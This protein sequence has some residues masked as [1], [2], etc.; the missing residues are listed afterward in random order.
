MAT[1]R[2]ESLAAVIRRITLT[3]TTYLA[4]TAIYFCVHNFL[5]LPW[6]FKA[7]PAARTLYDSLGGFRFELTSDI[8][9]RILTAGVAAIRE[10]LALWDIAG[11]GWGPALALAALAAAVILP[12]RG[13][14]RGVA[15]LIGL[16]GFAAAS[17]VPVVVSAGGAG[18]LRTVAPFSAIILG[19]GLAGLVRMPP[20]LPGMA[21][22]G[23]AAVASSIAIAPILYA[24]ATNS[25]LEIG[26]IRSALLEAMQADPLPRHIHVIECDPTPS[27][28][29]RPMLGKLEFN[30]NS[31]GG[32]MNVPWM[33]RSQ[34]KSMMSKKELPRIN[35]RKDPNEAAADE[36]AVTTSPA[37]SPRPTM[38]NGTLV[39]DMPAGRRASAAQWQ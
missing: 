1:M 9:G 4:S 10:G 18:G 30:V 24:S 17:L 29:G 12:L 22:G 26:Y 11:Q 15:A 28:M 39:I 3:A 27:F 19:C 33:I 34:L 23:A 20:R 6:Y 8:S 7:N 16:F 37:N 31:S 13:G 5:F 38:G 21:I 25:A 2:E 35:Y 32:W 14:W 36:V